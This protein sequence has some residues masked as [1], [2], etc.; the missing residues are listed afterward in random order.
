MKP[1]YIT[2]RTEHEFGPG[3]G[4]E[5]TRRAGLVLCESKDMLEEYINGTDQGR[6]NKGW[7]YLEWSFSFPRRIYVVELVW[8]VMLSSSGGRFVHLKCLPKDFYKKP[9]QFVRMGGECGLAL[10]YEG[11]REGWEGTAPARYVRHAGAWEV[12]FEWRD[13]GLFSISPYPQHPQLHGVELLGT[14][15]KQWAEDNGI[16][17]N[18]R[19]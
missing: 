15:K 8:N 13:E 11:E 5:Q 12:E 7:T 16:C 6:R 17:L 10:H 4:C 14:T 1:V 18:K 9:P 2:F 19:W 3:H